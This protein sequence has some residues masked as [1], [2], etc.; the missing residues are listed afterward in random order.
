MNLSRIFV[1]V[2]ALSFS[3]SLT[4]AAQLSLPYTGS[5]TNANPAFKITN[6]G[7]GIGIHAISVK[8]DRAIFGENQMAG[9]T[10]VYGIANVGLTSTGV[11][12]VSQNGRGVVGVTYNGEAGMKGANTKKDGIGVYGIADTGAAAMGVYG[13]SQNGRGVVGVTQNGEA[14]IK[15]GNNREGGFGVYGVADNGH[16]S[17]GVYGVSVNGRGV[18]GVTHHGESGVV[19]A[20]TRVHGFGVKGTA[21]AG[22]GLYGTSATGWGLLATSNMGWAAVF[23]NTG[24]E[25]VNPCVSVEGFHRGTGLISYLH[26]KNNNYPAVAA[27]N[28]G[29]GVAVYGEH[30]GSGTAAEFKVTKQSNLSPGVRIVHDGNGMGL[31]AIMQNTENSRPGIYAHTVGTGYGIQ[32][33][34]PA[35]GAIRADSDNGAMCTLATNTKGILTRTSAPSS[36]SLYS[37]ASGEGSY[38]GYFVGKVQ[39]VGNLAKSSG[40]FKI[41]H[42]LDPENKYLNHSFVESPDMMNVYNGNAIL[43]DN[44]EA[45]VYLPDYF[46]ALNEDFRYQLTCIGGFSPVYVAQEIEYN[47]FRIAGGTPGL[48]V[49]WQVTGVRQDAYANAHRIVVEEMKPA[50]ER[51]YFLHPAEHGAPE[52]L[53]INGAI[54][55]AD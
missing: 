29:P 18:V 30:P 50:N 48:K 19:G 35:A 2:I 43:D 41:D 7:T 36:H 38:A 27:Y 32:A 4:S 34:S 10:G 33:Y 6:L 17:A 8:G 15:G 9:G 45:W 22:Y 44:G 46:E 54:I 40:S 14:G 21:D 51:G 39:V 16:S 13:F 20:N 49:S 31:A 53:M 23:R 1:V 24:I 28:E 42:P 52:S 5:T 26:H 12:G 55:N 47:A 3:L 11:Y 37:S 25:N